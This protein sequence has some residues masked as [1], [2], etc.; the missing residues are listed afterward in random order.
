MQS[1]SG[2]AVCRHRQRGIKRGYSGFSKVLKIITMWLVL[3]TGARPVIITSGYRCPA[4]NRA[5]GGARL[6]QHLYG[7]AA[8][9]IVAAAATQDEATAKNVTSKTTPELIVHVPARDGSSYLSPD[10]V[11]DA[12]KTLGFPG[13]GRYQGFTHVDVRPN[14]PARWNR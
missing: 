14:G 7:N 4:H 13:V 10:I 2:A 9:I 12:A 6:S 8:D 11:V 3:V 1:N 5:V